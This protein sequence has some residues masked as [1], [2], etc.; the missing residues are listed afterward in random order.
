M[1]FGEILDWI[2]RIGGTITV[3]F[4]VVTY[5]A[6][7]GR[8]LRRKRDEVLKD[9]IVKAIEEQIPILLKDY[10][11]KFEE[12]GELI[13]DNK[14]ETNKQIKLLVQ[15]NKD[16][17]R[18]KMMQIYRNNRKTRTLNRYDREAFDE[19]YKDYKD[20]DGNSYVDKYRNRLVTWTVLDDPYDE[21]DE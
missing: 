9:K 1:P 7:P 12:I 15:G 16:V 4:V 21:N 5:F 10:D 6:K 19:L 3:I 8:F 20:H 18:Q 17:L 14:N 2:T 13:K 11:P